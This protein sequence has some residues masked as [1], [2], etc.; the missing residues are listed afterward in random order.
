MSFVAYFGRSLHPGRGSVNQGDGARWGIIG[1]AREAVVTESSSHVP[2]WRIR[3]LG[4]TLLAKPP[5]PLPGSWGMLSRARTIMEPQYRPGEIEPAVQRRWEEGR[6]FRAG[7]MDLPP[8]ARPAQFSRA[9]EG[10][11]LPSERT[12]AYQRIVELCWFPSSDQTPMNASRRSPTRLGDR[13][14]AARPVAS[15]RS[16]STTLFSDRFFPAAIGPEYVVVF[17]AASGGGRL[18]RGVSL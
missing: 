7:T 16:F 11:S 13:W 6:V 3:R 15:L 1:G 4:N 8:H 9:A 14:S 2:R 10:G 18:V 5:F 17:S 12:V